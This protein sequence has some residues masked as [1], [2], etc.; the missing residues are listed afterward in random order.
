MRISDWSSDVGSSDL[1]RSAEQDASPAPRSRR[2]RRLRIGRVQERGECG[3]WAQAIA[4]AH[5]CAMQESQLSQIVTGF[6]QAPI[7]NSTFP[8][9]EEHT[10]ELQSL[11][12]NSYAVFC[13]IK[14]KKSDT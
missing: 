7:R 5:P 13:L 2:H 14:K 11:M 3:F 8:R 4:K 9:S 12:R 10:S 1:R 6:L